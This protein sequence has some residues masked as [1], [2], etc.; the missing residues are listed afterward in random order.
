MKSQQDVSAIC[1]RPEFATHARFPALALDLSIAF[2]IALFFTANT[3]ADTAKT[4]GNLEITSDDG[5]FSASLGGMIHFDYYGFDPDI[6]DPISTTEFRRARIILKGKIYDWHYDLEQDFAANSTLSGFRNVFIARTFDS[7]ELRIGQF[8]PFRTMTEMTNANDYTFIERPFSGDGDFQGRLF[9]QGIGWLG[10]ERCLTYSLA[11][12]NLRDASG[13]RNEGVGMAGR[14]TWAPVL[15]DT[16]VLHL[17]TYISLENS[18][19]NTSDLVSKSNYA[20]RRGPSQ[21]MAS[22]P[23]ET[24]GRVSI[25]G[26]ELAGAYGPLYFQS[27]YTIS[28]YEGGYRL[29]QADFLDAYGAPAPFPCDAALGCFINDQNLYSWYL[30]G[31][32]MITGEHKPYN[33]KKGVFQSAHPNAAKDWLNGAWEIALRYD[34]AENRHIHGLQASSGIL[35]VNYYPNANTR[36][37]LNLIFGEDEFT[38]DSTNQLGIRAQIHW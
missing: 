29:S 5:N 2:S 35:G 20:G 3:Q 12:F 4:R 24:G 9:Q 14:V 18:N 10:Y 32:W 22:T 17:G 34:T 1:S 11:A 19:R 36:F 15:R 6:E 8:K 28:Q 25:A 27:E 7:G 16:E 13:P 38:G 37:M 30:Q 31:S 23:T 21:L 26:L 33:R